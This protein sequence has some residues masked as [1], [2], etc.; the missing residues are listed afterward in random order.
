[1]KIRVTLTVL[2]ALNIAANS[3]AQ[4]RD[5]RCQAPPYGASMQAYNMFA[6]E[7]AAS[8]EGDSSGSDKLSR[9]ARDLLSR[10]CEMKYGA[11]DRTELYRAGFTQEDIDRSSTIMLTAEYLGVTKYVA[12]QN[13]QREQQDRQREQP[14]V[15]PAV[16]DQSP[17]DYQAVSVRDFAENGRELAAA[18]AKVSLSGA[19]ILQGNREVLYA[20]VQAIIK[21]RYG[22][23]TGTQPSV[24]L[25]TN[26]ASDQFRRRSRSCQTD[27]S[28]AQVGCMVKIRGRAAMCTPNDAPGERREGPCVNV[29]DGK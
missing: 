1:M 27:P 28:A 24:V 21:T 19:Y 10:I 13:R 14:A 12:F 16:R 9:E 11:A 2:L 25:L 22:P 15:K 7:E 3:T 5:E 20:D 8:G 29:E 18:G 26:A 23:Q 6:T 17:G 4:S